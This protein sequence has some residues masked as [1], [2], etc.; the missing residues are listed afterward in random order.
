[1]SDVKAILFDFG[2]TLD[3]DGVDWFSRMY[4]SVIMRQPDLEREVF[5]AC[6][7]RAADALSGFADTSQLSMAETVGR[8]MKLTRGNLVACDAINGATW[9]ASEVAEEFMDQANVFLRRNREV[10]KEL[11]G[12]Y[13]LGCISNNWGNTAGWCAHYRL[14]DLFEVMVDSHR[15]GAMKPEARIFEVA[16]A[17][18]ALDASQC[19][20]VGDR[21]DCDVLGAQSVGMGSVWITRGD[22]YGEVDDAVATK[23]IARLEELLGMDF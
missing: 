15:V 21:F 1:M 23:R 9:E 7:R 20:Y 17:A 5:Q 11:G 18:M 10:L 8:I 3:H 14:D 2:G 13:R 22:Y 12:S 6:A 16:V 19:V 4:C